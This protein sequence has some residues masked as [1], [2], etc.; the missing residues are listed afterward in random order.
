MA[1]TTCNDE[2]TILYFYERGG[3]NDPQGNSLIPCPDCTPGTKN[4][5]LKDARKF[6][7]ELREALP[8]P[9]EMLPCK[10]CGSES[11]WC[12][13]CP[14]CGEAHSLKDCPKADPLGVA[15][16]FRQA[17]AMDHKELRELVDETTEKLA[18]FVAAQPDPGLEAALRHDVVTKMLISKLVIKRDLC[19]CGHAMEHHQVKPD[20]PKGQGCDQCTECTGYQQ[21]GTE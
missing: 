14:G 13:C 10:K 12:D 1:C 18:T 3:P 16:Y 17:M 8:A 5:F 19:Q 9:V 21:K 11:V 6:V 2:K 7:A 15:E 4:P 20:R